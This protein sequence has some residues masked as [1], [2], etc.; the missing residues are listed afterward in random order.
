MKID[1][2]GETRVGDAVAL[3]ALEPLGGRFVRVSSPQAERPSHTNAAY[4]AAKAVAEAWTLALAEEL[5]ERGG[6][7]NIVRVGTPVPPLPL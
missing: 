7:A 2:R 1:E 5:G 6:T 4:G 3:E